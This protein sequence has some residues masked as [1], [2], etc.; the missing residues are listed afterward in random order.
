MGLVVEDIYGPQVEDQEST[1][2][3]EYNESPENRSWAG[4]LPVK[5][6]LYDPENEKDACGVGFAAYVFLN[7]HWFSD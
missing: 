6:G 5:Q 3:Y 4:A 2:V 1:N 7:L